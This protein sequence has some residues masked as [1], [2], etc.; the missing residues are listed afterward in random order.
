MQMNIELTGYV[1][2]HDMT[3]NI[4]TIRTDKFGSITGG[5]VLITIARFRNFKEAIRKHKEYTKDMKTFLITP[6][7]ITTFMKDWKENDIIIT[8]GQNGTTQWD[9]YEI[10]DIKDVVFK[11]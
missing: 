4:I 3:K 5:Q 2:K 6:T 10:A 8:F 9:I 1:I 7:F 11:C